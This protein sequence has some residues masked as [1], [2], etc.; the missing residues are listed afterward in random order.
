MS[1]SDRD[2]RLEQAVKALRD[3]RNKQM[4]DSIKRTRELL[5]GR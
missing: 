3:K 1:K 5:K 2:K 4:Q